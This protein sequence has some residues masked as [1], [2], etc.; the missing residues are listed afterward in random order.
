[1]SHELYFIPMLARALESADTRTALRRAF[2]RIKRVGSEPRNADGFSSF[3]RFMDEVARAEATTDDESA[4]T[5][6]IRALIVEMV[7]G[8][9]E[10]DSEERRAAERFIRST[11]CWRTELDE[12]RA[13]WRGSGEASDVVVVELNRGDECLAQIELTPGKQHYAVS[14][15]EPGA[16]S[17]RV[18][19]GQLLWQG[20]LVRE[21]LLWSEAFPGRALD[22]AAETGESI[23]TPTMTDHLLDGELALTVY[24]G[25]ESGRMELTMRADGSG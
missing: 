8:T 2:E 11:S 9:F 25:L 4:Y 17:L 20:E 12:L 7:T 19:T 15:I 3:E 18:W 24:P 6:G 1:M 23:L 16:H 14:G 13:I 10:G 22:L 21:H 5:H